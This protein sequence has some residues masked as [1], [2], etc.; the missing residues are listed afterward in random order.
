MIQ[1]VRVAMSRQEEDLWIHVDAAYA[2]AAWAL[3]EFRKDSWLGFRF[4]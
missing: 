1:H 4:L 3:D 2:G